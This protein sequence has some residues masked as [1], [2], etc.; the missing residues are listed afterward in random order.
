MLDRLTR[1]KWNWLRRPL[2]TSDDGIA[3]QQY[4]GPR[5]TTEVQGDQRTHGK[6]I[7]RRKI[8]SRLAY[9]WSS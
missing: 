1:R 9:S 6:E 3:K 2:R 5:K 7:W 8:D 4:I